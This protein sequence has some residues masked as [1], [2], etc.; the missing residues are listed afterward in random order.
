[1]F[2]REEERAILL[3]PHLFYRRQ[4]HTKKAAIFQLNNCHWQV[5]TFVGGGLSQLDGKWAQDEREKETR[6]VSVAIQWLNSLP[7]FPVFAFASL[8][9]CLSAFSAFIP[10]VYP[11]DSALF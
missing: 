11:Q 1:L 3:F 5:F 6:A 4:R 2:G 8:L 10:P 9:L 7:V